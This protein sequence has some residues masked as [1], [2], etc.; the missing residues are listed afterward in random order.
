MRLTL[1]TLLALRNKTLSA[2]DEAV[3]SEKV[4]ESSYAQQLL[5]S[6]AEVVRNARLSALPPSATGPTDDPNV[7]AEYLD[8]TLPPEQAAEVDRTCLESP[9][10]LGEAAG[11]HE[12]LTLVLGKPAEVPSELRDRVYEIRNH[13][14]ETQEA[15]GGTAALHGA[16]PPGA[17]G[18]AGARE[19]TLEP[20]KVKPVSLNDSGAF[21]AATR[22]RPRES[23]RLETGDEMSPSADVLLARRG[24]LNAAE[25]SEIFGDR[26]RTSRIV[27]WLVSLALLAVFLFVLKQA[28]G[29]LLGDRGTVATLTEDPDPQPRIEEPA[30]TDEPV[31]SDEPVDAVPRTAGDATNP[32]PP[33]LPP[34]TAAQTND[35]PTSSNPGPSNP[36][37]SNPAPAS[38]NP[39]SPDAAN[40]NPTR[41]PSDTAAADAMETPSPGDA[42]PSVESNPQDDLPVVEEVTDGSSGGDRANDVDGSM[43]AEEPDAP[44]ADAGVTPASDSASP[45]VTTAASNA[46]LIALPRGAEQW[47]RLGNETAVAVGTT[48]ITPPGFRNQVVAGDRYEL[49]AIGPTMLQIGLAGD[50][51]ELNVQGGRVVIVARQPDLTL[52][53]RFGSRLAEVHIPEAGG[54]L[55]VHVDAFRSPGTDPTI[56]ENRVLVTRALAVEGPLDWRLGE[57]A[58]ESLETDQQWTLIGDGDADITT[59]DEQPDWIER[60]AESAIETSARETLVSLLAEDQPIAMVLRGALSFRRAEVAALAAR[61]LLQMGH[62][63]V[64]FGTEGVL[65]DP[66]QKSY[67]SEHVLALKSR[68]DHSPAAAEDVLNDAL[69][70]DPAN[71][72]TLFRL[73]WDYSPE[74][75]QA[76]DDA[77]LVALLDSPHMA[78][79]VLAIEALRR[80]TG[81]T[82]FY[83][84]D[85]DVATRRKN[86]IKKWEARLRREDIRWQTVPIAGETSGIGF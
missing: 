32:T 48:L 50:Q 34:P 65:N 45:V 64:Y 2:Q 44:V 38:P 15:A 39:S 8:S 77:S 43:T 68:I 29:P 51:G 61:T 75:L 69:A 52:S 21:Q 37:P 6:I 59:M 33:E 62:A 24:Q 55:A 71:A 82:L 4:R 57:A 18:A 46:L 5:E 63:D 74:Q 17:D 27:P 40:P 22:L 1:R 58:A 66:K 36:G 12:V 20:T 31:E 41:N 78:V 42:S 26:L 67:W 30:S 60:A 25:A 7:M 23:T 86:D 11:A 72:Q 70:M 84:P 28:F 76:G 53:I 49:T 56:A 79:R 3:L 83:K 10:H 19:P 47:Q 73:L 54:T 80:I 81:T 9:L 14:A 13:I 16:V 85:Q 35:S